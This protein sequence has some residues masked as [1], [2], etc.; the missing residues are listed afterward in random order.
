MR[1]NDNGLH[2]EARHCVTRITDCF[3]LILV[4]DRPHL[5][6]ILQKGN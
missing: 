4:T 5:S 2:L 1:S 3:H 6:P